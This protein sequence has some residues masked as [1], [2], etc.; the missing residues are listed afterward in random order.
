[1]CNAFKT[2]PKEM[3]FYITIFLLLNSSLIFSQNMK[4]FIVDSLF[5]YKDSE[6]KIIIKPQFQYA[7]KF[8]ADYAIVAKH[9][10][11]GVINKNNENLINYEYEFLRPLDSTELLYGKRAE[12]FGEFFMGVLT[13]QDK[14][15]VPNIYSYIQKKNNFYIVQIDKSEIISKDGNGAFRTMKSV[16]GMLDSDG[17]EL[18]P[19]VYNR[20][21]WKTSNLL[22]VSKEL[23]GNYAL[24]NKDGTQ[25]TNFDFMVFG[26]FRNGIAKARIG[27]KFGFINEQ[28]KIEVPIIYDYCNEFENGISIVEKNKKYGA[29]NQK[30]EEIIK[31]IYSFE[32]VTE[33]LSKK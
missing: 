32:I 1:M 22:E 26:D 31:P 3:K 7:S 5:G 19:C 11:F 6:E 14:V 33:K 8:Y 18:I 21:D 10:K 9:G 28:G 25:L 27:D 29:I 16:Y 15:K 30:G 23:N 4:P 12:Y 2:V 20:I 17:N 13:L 24:F